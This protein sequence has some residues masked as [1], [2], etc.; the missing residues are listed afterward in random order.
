VAVLLA[1]IALGAFI[2]WH[3]DTSKS[4]SAITQLGFIDSALQRYRDERG[5]YPLELRQLLEL[6][7]DGNPF[8]WDV[9]M[10]VDPWGFAYQYNRND[11]PPNNSAGT[12][13]VWT[14]ER[15]F[16]PFTR[17]RTATNR[18]FN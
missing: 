14:K 16:L 7:R 6:G 8:I 2:A 3:Q 13:L 12:P 1:L 5:D 4:K 17:Q 11:R 18:G 15:K 10:L 9:S